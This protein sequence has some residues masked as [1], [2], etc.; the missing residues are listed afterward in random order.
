M[1]SLNRF[2]FGSFFIFH[3]RREERKGV[4]EWKRFNGDVMLHSKWQRIIRIESECGVSSCKRSRIDYHFSM[5]FTFFCFSCVRWLYTNEFFKIHYFHIPCFRF[6]HSFIAQRRCVFLFFVL[7]SLPL[8]QFHF[9]SFKLQH[10][11]ELHL[12][13]MCSTYKFL[14]LLKRNF[15]FVVPALKSTLTHSRMYTYINKLESSLPSLE[16]LDPI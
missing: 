6:S 15:F 14:M 7:F 5:F 13:K 4:S 2:V 1:P 12:C 16:I 11:C 8:F 9:R 3:E 10:L